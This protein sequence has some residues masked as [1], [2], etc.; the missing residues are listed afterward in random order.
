MSFG[1]SVIRQHYKHHFS[2]SAFLSTILG[3]KIRSYR[4]HFL[5]KETEAQAM[6][7]QV[8]RSGVFFPYHSMLPLLSLPKTGLGPQVEGHQGLLGA[9]YPIGHHCH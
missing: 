7:S 1:A 9:T 3:R 5:P 6:A 8:V 2:F 4:S